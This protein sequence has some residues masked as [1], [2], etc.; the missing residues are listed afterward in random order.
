MG[1][2]GQ[3]CVAGDVEGAP[4]TQRDSSVVIV[5]AWP[6]CAA[7]ACKMASSPLLFVQHQQALCLLHG[8]FGVCFLRSQ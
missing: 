1:K 2:G 4:H 3:L 7:A 8:V 5:S 6:Q